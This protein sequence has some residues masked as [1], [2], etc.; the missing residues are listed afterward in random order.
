MRK[1]I[2]ELRRLYL[3]DEGRYGDADLEPHLRGERTMS[4]DLANGEGLARALMIEFRKLPDEG[5]WSQLCETAN[6]LQTELGLPAPAVSV[7]GGD[8]YGLWLSLDTPVPAARLRQ[9]KALLHQAYFAQQEIDTDKSVVELP[10]CLHQAS[11]LWAAFINPGMGASFADDLGLDM[12]PP[13]GAQTAFL[14]GLRGMTAKEFEHALEVLGRRA[15][16][17]TGSAATAAPAAA[18]P[19]NTSATAAGLLLKDASIED[20]V[21]HLQER[22]IEP[23]FRFLN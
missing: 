15:G 1:L 9:L 21:R 19:A 6:A 7:S 8:S 22:N 4:V 20:I 14:E 5:H 3:P 12:Q 11:G 23:T 16:A 17:D 10:P 18:A 13:V 2:A